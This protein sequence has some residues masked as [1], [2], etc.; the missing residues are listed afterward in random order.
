ME[1]V[2][3]ERPI[4]TLLDQLELEHFRLSSGISTTERDLL[5]QET[6]IPVLLCDPT[7][8]I[9]LRSQENEFNL[10]KVVNATEPCHKCKQS[11]KLFQN[12]LQCYYCHHYYCSNCIHSQQTNI[13]EFSWTRPCQVCCDCFDSIQQQKAYIPAILSLN[14][15]TSAT[16]SS[17]HR[18]RFILSVQ[19]AAPSP[20]EVKFSSSQLHVPVSDYPHSGI[21]MSVVRTNEDPLHNLLTRFISQQTKILSR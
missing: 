5:L 11:I 21:L 1:G 8:T 4:F 15:S 14:S 20:T 10:R 3:T 9:H 16:T 19:R 13:P 17:R 7:H 2:Y 18:S 6:G 12:R